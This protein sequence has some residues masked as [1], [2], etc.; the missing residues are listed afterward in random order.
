[1]CGGDTGWGD[2]QVGVHL[3]GL[4]VRVSAAD[5]LA[6]CV[7]MTDQGTVSCDAHPGD[8]HNVPYLYLT[9]DGFQGYA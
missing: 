7:S 3:L 9:F 1:M 8:L 4:A 5:P 6:V 2:E